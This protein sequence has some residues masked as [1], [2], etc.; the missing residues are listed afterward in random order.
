VL[1][2][3]PGRLGLLSL[4]S[5]GLPPEQAFDAMLDIAVE[6]SDRIDELEAKIAELSN[7]PAP[8]AS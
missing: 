5:S 3:Y 6:Q 4:Y 7:K 1:A 2:T 8:V